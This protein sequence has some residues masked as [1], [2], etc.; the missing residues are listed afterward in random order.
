[1]IGGAQVYQYALTNHLVQRVILTEIKKHAEADAFFPEL[2][3]A[4]TEISRE[5]HFDEKNSMH[6]DFVDYRLK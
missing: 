1:M 2:N 6:F 5:S 4:W 3:E